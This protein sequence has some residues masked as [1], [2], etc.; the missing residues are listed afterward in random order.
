MPAH[1]HPIVKEP[2]RNEYYLDEYFF[3]DDP[4]LTPAKR[5]KLENRGGSGIVRLQRRDGRWIG[6]RDLVLGMMIPNYR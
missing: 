1:V 6:R 2:E 3:D 5:A 4:R